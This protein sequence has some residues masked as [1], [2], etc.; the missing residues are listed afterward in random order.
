MTTATVKK[1]TPTKATKKA[2]AEP[3]KPRTRREA[4]EYL[5]SQGYSGPTSFTMTDLLLV[6]MWVEAGSPRDT[7][8]GVPNGALYAVHADM[9]PQPARKARPLTKY[10]QGYQAALAE[11]AGLADMQAV[12]AW[13]AENRVE[14]SA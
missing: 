4:L 5:R 1:A 10:A 13:V 11:V 9:R 8:T 3:A 6:C 14:V 7:T 12:Q 2:P